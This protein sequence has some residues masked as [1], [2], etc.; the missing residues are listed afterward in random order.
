MNNKLTGDITL[1]GNDVTIPA[2]A[3]IAKGAVVNT[4][5]PHQPAKEA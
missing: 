4:E 5:N 2:Q 1:I 3:Y